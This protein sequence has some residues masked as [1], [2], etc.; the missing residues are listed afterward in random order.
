MRLA[1]VLASFNLLAGACAPG[2]KPFGIGAGTLL[3][4]VGSAILIDA[5]T[6]RCPAPPP[7]EMGISLPFSG[8]E[9]A[10]CEAG[11]D[12]EKAAGTVVLVGGLVTLL[13]AALSPSATEPARAA[14]PPPL[15]SVPALAPG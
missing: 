2:A 3:A 14:V 13:A 7:P 4:T 11:V 5:K 6:T 10:V 12:L 1:A 9:S 8:V 15:V